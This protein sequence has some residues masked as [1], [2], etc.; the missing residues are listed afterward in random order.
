MPTYKPE[1]NRER[2]DGDVQLFN[3]HLKMTRSQF[4]LAYN[5]KVKTDRHEKN[6]KKQLEFVESVRWVER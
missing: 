6:K 5:A 1:G 3:V 2:G 4:S